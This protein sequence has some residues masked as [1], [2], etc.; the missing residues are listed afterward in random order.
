MSGAVGQA[1]LGRG[2]GVNVDCGGFEDF[3]K[4]FREKPGK[5]GIPSTCVRL[6]EVR[7]GR[8][9]ESALGTLVAFI[10]HLRL[11]WGGGTRALKCKVQIAEWS[12]VC[13]RKGISEQVTRPAESLF[14]TRLF[15][16]TGCWED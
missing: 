14:F 7:K 10:I 11:R 9:W 16:T 15:T 4:S 3:L 5:S 1:R 6:N 8:G 13:G 2:T 12:R